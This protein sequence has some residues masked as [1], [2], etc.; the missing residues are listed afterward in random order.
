MWRLSGHVQIRVTR[1]AGPNAVVSGLFFDP[2]V[3]V[4]ALGDSNKDGHFDMADLNQLVDFLLMRTKPDA[5]ASLNS[6]VNGDGQFTM[7]DLNLYVDCLLG[8]ISKF[9]V[10]PP[11]GL[12]TCP[13]SVPSGG[14]NSK[15]E[16]ATVS[17]PAAMVSGFALSSRLRNNF[18]GLVGMKFTVGIPSIS[19]Y[20]V[21]RICVAGN[22][23]THLVKIVNAATGMDVPG[24]SAS[25]DMMH[26]TPGQFQYATLAGLANLQ[27]GAAY[28]LVSQENSGGDQWY[29]Y[30]AISTTSAVTVNS[31][32][33]FDGANWQPVGRPTPPMC[34]PVSSTW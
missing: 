18:S 27:A 22:Q 7:A 16:W 19:V 33:W 12:L 23:Q 15:P 24:G 34:R 6:D 28:Y 29:D 10:G 21:G 8:R 26:C 31:A 1:T 3:L 20:S 30:G 13:G 14:S 4:A 11:A 25:V 5:Q 9:P 2:E 17:A 32:I